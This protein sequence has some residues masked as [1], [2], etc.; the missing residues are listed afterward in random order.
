M[1]RLAFWLSLGLIFVI[2]WE[3]SVDVGSLGTV[4]RGV[5]MLAAAVWVASV[6][7]AG[8]SRRLHEFHAVFFFFVTWNVAS[9]VWSQDVNATLDRIV[10]YAQLFVLALLVWDLYETKEALEL[11][12]QAYVLGALVSVGSIV[13]NYL[14]LYDPTRVRYSATGFDEDDIG[15][16][17]A[18]GVPI[19]L[20]LFVSGR[21]TAVGLPLRLIN[22]G[23]M[24]AAAL[25]IVLTATR[26]SFLAM[27]PAAVLGLTMFLRLSL[28]RRLV[29][30]AIAA[31]GVL[32]V[33]TVAPQSS[34]ERVTNTGGAVAEGDF[35][36]RLE[37][38]RDGLGVWAEQPVLGAG[39]GSFRSLVSVSSKQKVAH[40][41][42]LS[43]LTELG[44]VGFALFATILAIV[45]HQATHS[46]SG[47][48]FWPAL[49]ATWAIGATALTWEPRK[50]TWL[51][52]CLVVVGA[53]AVGAAARATRPE[54][55]GP[56]Q[57]LLG[58]RSLL[59]G[60]RQ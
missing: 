1:R 56:G 58:G 53:N 51:V 32:V 45:V 24:P 28:A 11:G 57:K 29:V 36:G 39:A 37:I 60:A 16:I 40:N 12:L 5:G 18:I 9:V 19:A 46:R 42:Y 38:W 2:P 7:L 49:F 10:T 34:F 59:A 13:Y 14:T 43:V 48:G 3:N 26:G 33:T 47:S 35:S 30:C 8:R 55:A 31:G 6:A 17:L 15:L 22:L 44:L 27:M 4:G 21:N 54:P 20:H 25:A 41:T 52:L 50:P 23:Y